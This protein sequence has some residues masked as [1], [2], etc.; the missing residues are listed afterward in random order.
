MANSR[1]V[2][3]HQVLVDGMWHRIRLSGPILHLDCRDARA[4]DVWVL[5]N[6]GEP[7]CVREFQ[8]FGTGQVLPDDA[9]RHVGTVL[10]PDSP[11]FARRGDL[12]WH[13]FERRTLT[14]QEG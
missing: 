3:R 2:H 1:V 11:P 7:S 13:V 9:G 10:S 8:A 14:S 4:V 5:E 6:V 12:V